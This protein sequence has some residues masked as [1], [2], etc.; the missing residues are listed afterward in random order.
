MLDPAHVWAIVP[1]KLLPLAKS[2]LAPA[3]S[4][5]ERAS[6][7]LAML[8][9]VLDQLLTARNV[10]RWAVVSPDTRVLGLATRRGGV[11]IRDSGRGLND[12]LRQGLAEVAS[13]GAMAVLMLPADLPLLRSEE[14]DALVALAEESPCMIIAP[15]ARDGGTNALLVRPPEAMTP[16]FGQDSFESHCR[17]ARERGIPI[18]RFEAPGL[19]LDLDTPETLASIGALTNGHYRVNSPWQKRRAYGEVARRR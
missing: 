4:S 3:M 18:H 7:C 14:L 10:G 15:A 2:R 13:R 11:G 12:A 1:V 17:Q 19:A 6:L 16:C 9:H 8:R 5:E